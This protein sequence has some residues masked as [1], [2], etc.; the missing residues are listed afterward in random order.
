MVARQWLM[1]P[2]IVMA[3]WP[4]DGY[5]T[6]VHGTT[7]SNGSMATGWLLDNGSWYYLNSTAQWPQ[8]GCYTMAH[9]TTSIVNGSMATG[10][11]LTMVHGTTSTVMAI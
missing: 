4:Q 8:D 1:V 7:N 2:P 3:Q 5:Q 11:L 10:W 6:M 9:G